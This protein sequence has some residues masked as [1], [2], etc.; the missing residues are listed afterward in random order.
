[1]KAEFSKNYYLR[2]L[3]FD[4]NSRILPRAVLEIFQDIAG[5]H[6]ENDGFGFDVLKNKNLEVISK[7]NIFLY[8]SKYG[9]G[10]LLF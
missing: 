10:K 6:A 8:I 2:A 9:S 1:M 5:A 7:M 3:D 4:M